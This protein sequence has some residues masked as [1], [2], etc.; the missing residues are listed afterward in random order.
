MGK[1]FPNF[2]D[3]TSCKQMMMKEINWIIFLLL[4]IHKKLLSTLENKTDNLSDH[5]A[6][7]IEIGQSI[8]KKER[9]LWLFNNGLVKTKNFL[10]VQI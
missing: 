10:K 2:S 9:G 1:F 6:T 3:Y 5:S 8:T 7:W 4:Q